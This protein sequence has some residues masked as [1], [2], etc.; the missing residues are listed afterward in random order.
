MISY[1]VYCKDHRNMFLYLGVVWVSTLVIYA[2]LVY[3]CAFTL[4]HSA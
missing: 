4:G 3:C 1:H 2:F